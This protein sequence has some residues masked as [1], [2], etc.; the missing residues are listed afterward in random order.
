MPQLV[1][2]QGEFGYVGLTESV[3]SG[4]HRLFV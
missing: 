3:A 4:S 1:L 2:F